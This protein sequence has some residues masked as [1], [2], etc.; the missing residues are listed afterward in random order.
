MLASLSNTDGD[1]IFTVVR[2][3]LGI[4]FFAHFGDLG[5]TLR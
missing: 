5:T 2:T 3:V 1:W 4:I